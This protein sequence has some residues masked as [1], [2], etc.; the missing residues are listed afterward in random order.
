MNARL[1]SPWNALLSN[2]CQLLG[3]RQTD[4]ISFVRRC[5]ALHPPSLLFHCSPP[6]TM[7]YPDERVSLVSC[8]KPLGCI[9]HTPGVG[10]SSPEASQE[11]PRLL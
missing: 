10:F 6:N 8:K 7:T 11:T 3:R 2:D 9:T 5:L 1:E 4:Y